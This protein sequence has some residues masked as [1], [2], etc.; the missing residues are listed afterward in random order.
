MTIQV[1]ENRHARFMQSFS[2]YLL[3]IYYKPSIV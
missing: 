2:K 3:S 1:P